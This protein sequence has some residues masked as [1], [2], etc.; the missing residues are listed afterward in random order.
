MGKANKPSG[1]QWFIQIW[2]RSSSLQTSI[3][4][5]FVFFFFWLPL[6]HW[7]LLIAAG[8][9]NWWA[10]WGWCFL[11]CMCRKQASV[12]T[13]VSNSCFHPH[14]C[15]SA[16]VAIMIASGQRQMC[17]FLSDQEKQ[18]EA[19][20]QTWSSSRRWLHAIL[21]RLLVVTC[22]WEM[23]RGGALTE[24]TA[25]TGCCLTTPVYF[26][27]CWRWLPVRPLLIV[28][29]NLLKTKSTRCLGSGWGCL[30]GLGGAGAGRIHIV[31]CMF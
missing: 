30:Q 24:Q 11:L 3:K 20:L 25:A 7:K 14:F 27:L 15:G 1:A 9:N 2:H 19:F 26:S 13:L 6:E 29:S 10:C 17:C 4:I 8:G 16:A 21:P 28:L 5:E 12:F 23:L 18:V 31:L 22:S